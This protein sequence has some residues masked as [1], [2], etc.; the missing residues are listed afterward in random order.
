MT[1]SRWQ[2]YT[3]SKWH[4]TKRTGNL[5]DNLYV[6][7]Y[8][9]AF[10]K[11]FQSFNIVHLKTIINLQ[12]FSVQSCHHR[13]KGS[14]TGELHFLLLQPWRQ[15]YLI[16]LREDTDACCT[17][18]HCGLYIPVFSSI[19]NSLLDLV[20]IS[21]VLA[22]THTHELLYAAFKMCWCKAIFI[23][24]IFFRKGCHFIEQ[25]FLV[26]KCFLAMSVFV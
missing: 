11:D 24:T 19:H 17:V 21:P 25:T 20:I 6:S 4:L 3:F 7:L 14:H 10:S 22:L 9:T 12:K 13:H 2:T 15:P 26:N 8:V 1:R 16:R 23:L 5:C 18:V